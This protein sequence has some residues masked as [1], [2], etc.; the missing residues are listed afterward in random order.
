MRVKQ[1][2]QRLTDRIRDQLS[3]L[4]QLKGTRKQ[5]ARALQET[6][7]SIA[8]LAELDTNVQSKL[9]VDR[10]NVDDYGSNRA[11]L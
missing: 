1:R 7:G 5:I 8:L 3:F 4:G 9:R 6:E 11:F 2:L 10:S